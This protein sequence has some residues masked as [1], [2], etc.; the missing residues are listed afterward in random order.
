MFCLYT[1]SKLSRPWFEF[2][3]KR[4]WDQIQAIFLNLFYFTIIKMKRKENERKEKKRKGY[5]AQC[6]TRNR[7]NKTNIRLKLLVVED[8]NYML[9]IRE[10]QFYDSIADL[11]TTHA[12]LLNVTTIWNV[13][14]KSFTLV[15]WQYWR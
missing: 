11:T 4:W 12:L 9:E 6:Q 14:H 2:L 10:D 5:T 8:F 13:N 3:L 1:L 15:S 7:T